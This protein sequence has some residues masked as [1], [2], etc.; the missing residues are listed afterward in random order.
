MCVGELLLNC[1]M[2]SGLWLE[3]DFHYFALGALTKV[4]H[5]SHSRH[6]SVSLVKINWNMDIG[7]EKK[8]STTH[9]VNYEPVLSSSAL[10]LRQEI[11]S[12]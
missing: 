10:C 7:E 3:N 12:G 9:I 4:F 5:G 1:S 6:F 2:L 11:R 8:T